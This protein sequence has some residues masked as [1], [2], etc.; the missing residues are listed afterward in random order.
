MDYPLQRGK[1]SLNFSRGAKKIVL[2]YIM[3]SLFWFGVK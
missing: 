2:C 3:F 1:F